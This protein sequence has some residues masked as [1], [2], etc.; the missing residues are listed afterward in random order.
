LLKIIRRKIKIIVYHHHFN[1][2]TQTG[3]LKYI[4]KFFELLFLKIIDTTII[5]SPYVKD[6]MT[7]VLPKSN[8]KYIE[9]GFDLNPYFEKDKIKVNKL[10]YVGTVERR[11]GIHHLIY[12]AEFLIKQKIECH[13]DI[14]GSLSDTF[15]VESVKKMINDNRL[16]EYITLWGRVDA[17]EL[18][19]LYKQSDV[20]V[21]PSS[22]E[23]YGMVLIEALSYGLPVIAFNNSAIPYTI[24]NY[25]NGLLASEGDTKDFCNKVKEILSDEDLWDKLRQNACQ[26]TLKTHTLQHMQNDMKQFINGL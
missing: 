2:Y 24:K 9:I 17:N 21:F 16:N 18:E 7:N 13:I 23:G 6:E 14:V 5:P 19:A 4:H 1:Y 12:L 20:F 10:L 25:F 26:S 15:Y 22:H 3:I 11:K 8:Y